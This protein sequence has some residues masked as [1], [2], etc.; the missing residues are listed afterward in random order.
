MRSK[1]ALAV[2]AGMLLQASAA[3]TPAEEYRVKGAFLLNFANYV[4]WPAQVF[5][6]SGGPIAICVLGAT[7][8]TA[9]LDAAARK[10]LA[11]NRPVTVQKVTDPQN[12]RECQIVFVSVSERKQVHALLK[13]VRGDSVLTVGESEG[14]IASGGVIEFRV[15]ESKVKMEINADAAKHA[16]LAISSRLLNLIQ[17]GKK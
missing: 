5:K 17:S 10:V 16:R 15:E 4:E 3:E 7:L 11:Q 12:A 2:L 9:E 14:F 8:F 13:A 1:L 6:S